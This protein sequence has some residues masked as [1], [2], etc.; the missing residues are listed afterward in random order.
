MKILGPIKKMKMKPFKIKDP[1]QKLVEHYP[2]PKLLLRVA[3]EG[4]EEAQG[5][6]AR[7]WLSEG[8]PSVFL[9]C[10]AVYDTLRYWL[11]ECL[12]VHPKEIGLVGSAHLGKS[13]D[14][15]K[16]GAPFIPNKSDLDLFIVSKNLFERLKKDFFDWSC[17]F[18]N[19]K[20]NLYNGESKRRWKR[21]DKEVSKNIKRGFIDANRIPSRLEYPTVRKVQ[22]TMERLVEKLKNTYNSPSPKYASIRCYDSWDSFVQQKSLNLRFLSQKVKKHST[23]GGRYP[24]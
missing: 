13:L 23:D 4:G 20:I 12:E 24:S 1:L 18:K 9:P 21:N 11:G 16:I 5:V 10:P 19:G 2:D 14:P 6:I 22:V 15:Y 17:D 8:I 3:R 7:L